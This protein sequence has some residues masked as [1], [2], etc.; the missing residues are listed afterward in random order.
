MLWRNA[1]KC[2]RWTTQE[3]HEVKLYIRKAASAADL[4]LDQIP[5]VL[6]LRQIMVCQHSLTAIA[7]CRARLTSRCER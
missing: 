1:D 7:R 3:L 2:L 4:C 6:D 5:K